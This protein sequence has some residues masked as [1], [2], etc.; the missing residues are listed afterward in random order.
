MTQPPLDYSSR[1]PQRRPVSTGDAVAGTFAAL[2]AGPGVAF[3]AALFAEATSND[4]YA[5][6]G[7]L[8][9][10]AATGG[11]LTLILLVVGIRKSRS[12]DGRRR[13]FGIG[14]MI[15]TGISL[16]GVGVC[17]AVIR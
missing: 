6:L 3:G 13:G 8:V 10:G 11:L 17:F 2:L 14:L 12:I 1:N 16:L 5:A 7:G 9:V 4:S 15:G